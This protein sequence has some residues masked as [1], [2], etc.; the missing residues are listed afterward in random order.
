MLPLEHAV[1]QVTDCPVGSVADK[2]AR[3]SQTVELVR[4]ALD[5]TATQM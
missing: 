1:H 5:K 4:N 2:V 3:M